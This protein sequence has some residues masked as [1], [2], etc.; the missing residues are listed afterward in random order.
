M[1]TIKLVTLSFILFSCASQQENPFK[2]GKRLGARLC[3]EHGGLK[4][5][6]HR[7][8]FVCNDG[9]KYPEEDK[10]DT[11]YAQDTKKLKLWKF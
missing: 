11:F 1:K 6:K 3:V 2:N 4:Y 9:K 7:E 5:N 8:L 10:E